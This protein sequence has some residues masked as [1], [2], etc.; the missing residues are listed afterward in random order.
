MNPP[1]DFLE[2][3]KDLPKVKIRITDK[4]VRRMAGCEVCL[5]WKSHNF[6]FAW[7]GSPIGAAPISN[8]DAVEVML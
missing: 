5:A 4:G 6:Y 2:K 8:K 3:V 7:L 1:A